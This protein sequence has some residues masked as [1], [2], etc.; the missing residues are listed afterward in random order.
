MQTSNSLLCSLGRPDHQTRRLVL[1][2]PQ[3]CVMQFWV[4]EIEF[5]RTQ[6][7]KCGKFT[8]ARGPGLFLREPLWQESQYTHGAH[9]R[10]K[11]L[12]K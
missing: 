5:L 2:V 4:R 9:E 10:K 3:L 6:H 1:F 7:I 12:Y 11:I 8:V